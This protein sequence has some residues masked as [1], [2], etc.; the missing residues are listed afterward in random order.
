MSVKP[1]L[2]NGV[3]VSEGRSEARW[4]LALPLLSPRRT[5]LAW[6]RPAGPFRS[7]ELLGESPAQAA[8][9][10]ADERWP[11]QHFLHPSQRF[12]LTDCASA[13]LHHSIEI[14]SS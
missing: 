6:Y 9:R 7:N 2:P 4:V 13:V 10:S 8:E 3:R 5:S 1:G 14:A 12:R 11:K